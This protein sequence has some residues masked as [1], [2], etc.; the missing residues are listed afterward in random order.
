[1]VFPTLMISSGQ[2]DVRK[3]ENASRI[4]LIVT[5]LIVSQVPGIADG[6][7]SV[8]EALFIVYDLPLMTTV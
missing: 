7:L 3:K 4:N 5:N 1:M 8:P 6:M 2:T